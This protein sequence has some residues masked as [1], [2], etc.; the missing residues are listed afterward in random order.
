MRERRNA[1]F[2]LWTLMKE[3][4]KKKE[5]IP[6]KN[7]RAICFR[8]MIDCHRAHV[9]LGAIMRFDYAECARKGLFDDRVGN[10]RFISNSFAGGRPLYT[11]IKKCWLADLATPLSLSPSSTHRTAS[12]LTGP[13]WRVRSMRWNSHFLSTNIKLDSCCGCSDDQ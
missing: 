7:N 6:W 4:N 13:G 10:F 9:N 1:R 3:R 12:G 5:K 2:D 8:V 11:D